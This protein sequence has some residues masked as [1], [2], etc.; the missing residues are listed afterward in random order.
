MTKAIWHRPS[1]RRFPKKN[2]SKL[3]L[4]REFRW[5]AVG[6]KCRYSDR[7]RRFYRKSYFVVLQLPEKNK[8]ECLQELMQAHFHSK[9]KYALFDAYFSEL[10]NIYVQ[11]VALLRND[12]YHRY[13]IV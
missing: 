4:S 8:A 9:S 2:R 7:H 6:Q 13:F 12:L 3:E 10:M 5:K 1:N 11:H